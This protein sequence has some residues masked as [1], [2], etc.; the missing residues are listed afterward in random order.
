MATA[1]KRM[2]DMSKKRRALSSNEATASP[3]RGKA[4]DAK[5]HRTGVLATLGMTVVKSEVNTREKTIPRENLVQAT[6]YV[7]ITLQKLL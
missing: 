7:E 4:T 1:P 5:G 6:E 3:Q 2:Y